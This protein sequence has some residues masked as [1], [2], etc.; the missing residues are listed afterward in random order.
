MKKWMAT[1]RTFEIMREMQ[2][3]Q[4]A[5]AEKIKVNVH[6]DTVRR[7]FDMQ[8]EYVP[9]LFC[10]TITNTD[11]HVDYNGGISVYTLYKCPKCTHTF[12]EKDIHK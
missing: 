10:G 2:A 12:M 7:V 8:K 4:K 3:A 5:E 11:V 9:C 6:P 1:S